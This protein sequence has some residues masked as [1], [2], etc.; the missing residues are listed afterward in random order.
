MLY[1]SHHHAIVVIIIMKYLSESC[2]QHDK[3]VRQIMNGKITCLAK[4]HFISNSAI[5]HLCQLFWVL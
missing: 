2:C 5:I 3:L 4:S 1:C